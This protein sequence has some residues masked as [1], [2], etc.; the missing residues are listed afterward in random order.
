[1]RDARFLSRYVL[2]FEAAIEDAVM[3][4]ANQA[5]EDNRNVARMAT[6]LAGM[7]L[8]GQGGFVARLFQ[9]P[10]SLTTK[11]EI[12]LLTM[13]SITSLIRSRL[14]RGAG[15]SRATTPACSSSRPGSRSWSPTPRPIRLPVRS[16]G[17]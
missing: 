8:G 10:M 9:V 12:W 5:G 13:L 2:H 4:C 7:A 3:G 11:A 15:R 6:L 14:R 17:S 16:T 1:M